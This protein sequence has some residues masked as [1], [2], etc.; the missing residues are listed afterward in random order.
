M[1]G[2]V[3]CPSLGFIRGRLSAVKLRVEYLLS[4]SF[5]TSVDEYCRT[6]I[7]FCK[8]RILWHTGCLQ[9]FIDLSLSAL[10]FSLQILQHIICFQCFE[11]WMERLLFVDAE[12]S[13]QC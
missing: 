10:I 13:D 9:N 2:Y 6:V 7:S 8:Q 11:I 1:G 4:I 5:L 3:Y 12:I